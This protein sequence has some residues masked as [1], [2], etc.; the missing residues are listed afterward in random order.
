MVV[1]YGHFQ[2]NYDM[3]R[4]LATTLMPHNCVLITK[5]SSALNKVKTEA[6]IIVLQSVQYTMFNMNWRTIS[7]ADHRSRSYAMK[8]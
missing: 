3:R 6:S 2:N 7:K 1:I 5:A 8:K 4:E